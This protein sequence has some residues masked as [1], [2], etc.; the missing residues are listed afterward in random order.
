LASAWAAAPLAVLAAVR[1]VLVVGLAA[2]ARAAVPVTPMVLSGVALLAV[3][4]GGVAL[5][6]LLESQP[7]LLGLHF[8]LQLD[9]PRAVAVA[10]AYIPT[11]VGR[12]ARP[13]LAAGWPLGVDRFC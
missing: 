3:A 2:V 12:A 7:G 6:V 11:L 5:L 9:E 10:V 4:S 8:Q 1:L 13:F